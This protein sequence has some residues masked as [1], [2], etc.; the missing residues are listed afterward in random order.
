MSFRLAWVQ[1]RVCWYGTKYQC[2]EFVFIL[3]INFMLGGCSLLVIMAN[4]ESN[5]CIMRGSYNDCVI[6]H[7][8]T[9]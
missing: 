6:S 4:P 5:L 2:K 9:A 7:E 3:I 8:C 1:A